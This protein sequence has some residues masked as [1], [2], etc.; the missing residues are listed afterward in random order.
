MRFLATGRK[1]KLE[2]ND[3]IFGLSN[4]YAR[5]EMWRCLQYRELG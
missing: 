5:Y 2:V 3:Y 4:R 1:E